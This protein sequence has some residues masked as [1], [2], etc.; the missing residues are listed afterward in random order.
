MSREKLWGISK[1]Y[2]LNQWS[3]IKFANSEKRMK[4]L[5]VNFKTKQTSKTILGRIKNLV[6]DFIIYFAWESTLYMQHEH[7]TKHQIQYASLEEVSKKKLWQIIFNSNYTQKSSKLLQWKMYISCK[8]TLEFAICTRNMELLK[9]YSKEKT[10]FCSIKLLF[11]KVKC[12][13]NVSSNLGVEIFL[14]KREH[15]KKTR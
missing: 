13:I 8:Y 6:L 10:F 2:F 1:V 5:I 7:R 15:Q 14:K 4:I 3:T 11:I 12:L 9:L